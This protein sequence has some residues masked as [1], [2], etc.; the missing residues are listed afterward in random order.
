MH[1]YLSR[2]LA[3]CTTL[4]AF[5][6]AF[7]ADFPA[8]AVTLVVPY[9]A[10]GGTDTVA[11]AIARAL[12]THW[13]QPVTVENVAG[14]D[15]SIGMNKALRNPA[16]GTTI[17]MQVNQM[18]LWRWT[19]PQIKTDVL[20]EVTLL[21]MVA[22]S[23]QAL[24]VSSKLPVKDM[25][26]FADWCE[27][28]PCSIASATR[29]AELISK[30]VVQTAGLKAIV[31]PYK[32]TAPMLSD[33]MGGHIT[34]AL[35][36]VSASLGHVRN[37][38]LKFLA[39]GSPTRFKATSEV[40]TLIEQKIPVTGEA[41]YGLMVAKATPRTALDALSEGIRAA[42]TDPA[43][44]EAIETAGAEPVF[45]TSPDF[46]QYVIKEREMLDSLVK[47]FPMAN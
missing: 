35:P 30:Q 37:G 33:L 10:G 22:R 44:L 5:G 23:P 12:S 1:R 13:R 31:V 32:G 39:V 41:W 47:K 46:T 45:S 9:P 26:E 24:V 14:G 29:L 16:D 17:V 38:T 3:L 43:V 2:F 25:K 8:K 11:R 19:L 40:P 18:L 36:A 4:L 15:G 21:S 28:H 34:M 6:P 7:G 42:S 27:T 20:D